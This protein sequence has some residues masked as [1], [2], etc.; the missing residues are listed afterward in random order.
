MMQT[1]KNHKST[2]KTQAEMRFCGAFVV[3]KK[4]NAL[5]VLQDPDIG[6]IRHADVGE[7]TVCL[8]RL[9]V[10]AFEMLIKNRTRVI[11]NEAQ[12]FLANLNL[13]FVLQNNSVGPLGKLV[14]QQQEVK[15]DW[16]EEG[17]E[18]R[19]DFVFL[20]SEGK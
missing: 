3:L 5:Q 2:I 11:R 10:T 1:H 8:H 4:E 20:R 15:R 9:G 18:I 12:G 6:C 13:S 19:I 14:V 16:L 17:E 7:K